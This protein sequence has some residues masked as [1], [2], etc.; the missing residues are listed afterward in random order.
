MYVDDNDM[1]MMLLQDAD[2]VD[3]HAV[4][5]STFRWAVQVC[6]RLILR[7]VSCWFFKN[8]IGGKSNRDEVGDYLR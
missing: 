7:L 8:A 4:L 6:E 1:L 3:S 2:K 5:M